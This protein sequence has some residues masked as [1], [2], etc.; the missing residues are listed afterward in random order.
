MCTIQS[1]TQKS[2]NY[3]LIYII[4]KK[5]NILKF[6]FFFFF[7]VC[8]FNDH[9]SN[10]IT[11]QVICEGHTYNVYMKLKLEHKAIPNQLIDSHPNFRK[12]MGPVGG[13]YFFNFHGKH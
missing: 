9:F 6:P 3:I 5:K 12:K 7:F 13:F 11:L 8:L 10:P 1:Q 4:E 2:I